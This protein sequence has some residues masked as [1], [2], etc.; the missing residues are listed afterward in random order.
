MGFAVVSVVAGAIRSREG[1]KHEDAWDYDI[2]RD[3]LFLGGKA[4]GQA[5]DSQ[6]EGES[7]FSAG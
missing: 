4:D 5:G 1:W 3:C 7:I 6:G 2:V